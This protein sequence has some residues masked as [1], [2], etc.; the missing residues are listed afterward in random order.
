MRKC[1]ETTPFRLF[2]GF[3]KIVSMHKKGIERV[4]QCMPGS[5]FRSPK[6]VKPGVAVDIPAFLQALKPGN[7]K[8]GPEAREASSA[9]A[10]HLIQDRS[11][12]VV[13]LRCSFT[14]WRVGFSRRNQFRGKLFHGLVFRCPE[15]D[16]EQSREC[17][18][19]VHVL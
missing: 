17:L 18:A 15:S 3:Q 16:S 11:P 5:H 9:F 12:L 10:D 2:F 1:I 4:H 8:Q 19:P 6:V 13:S 7:R 14:G